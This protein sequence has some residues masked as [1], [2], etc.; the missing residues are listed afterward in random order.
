MHNVKAC[1]LQG[2]PEYRVGWV[3]GMEGDTSRI[4]RM[5]IR[6]RCSSAVR[7]RRTLRL[8]GEKAS[9]S[10]YSLQVAWAQPG[11]RGPS[12]VPRDDI[13]LREGWVLSGSAAE[14]EATERLKP[15][16]QNS[17]TI[18]CGWVTLRSSPLCVSSGNLRCVRYAGRSTPA[19]A[20]RSSGRS[21]VPEVPRLC[22]GTT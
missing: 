10:I 13:T 19:L 2:M 1:I 5:G 6:W 14:H 17:S 11:S 22:L 16:L 3:A 20:T 21:Q 15:Q 7:L 12:A 8:C 9:R 18:V 4:C